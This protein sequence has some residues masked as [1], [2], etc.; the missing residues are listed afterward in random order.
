M[1]LKNNSNEKFGN[2][3]KKTKTAFTLAE[4]LIVLVVVGI[5]S[6]IS[7]PTLI[8]VHQKEEALTR[9]K[10]T[11]SALQ[12]T[13]YRAIADHGQPDTWVM[14]SGTSWNTARRFTETYILPYLSTADI[15]LNNVTSKCNYTIYNL[16]KT[17][18]NMPNNTFRFYLADG[19]F[20]FVYP[21]SNSNDKAAMIYFD[22]N[23]PKLPNRLG[24]DIYKIEYW[25]SSTS[26]GRTPQI[27]KVT[28]AYFNKSRAE[29][30]GTSNNEYC[31]K[32]KQGMACLAV[33]LEDSWT[34][35]DDYPW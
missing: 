17:V 18:Y 26:V 29:I 13:T 30:T 5:I 8:M 11:Y 14:N 16:N 35:A 25:I 27:G 21:V 22:I 31:N 9:I 24:R 2:I 10:K 23:G 34:F 6:S 19:T 4:T 33:I 32:T 15:C 28:P 20:L 1:F 12:Q 7:V 3:S